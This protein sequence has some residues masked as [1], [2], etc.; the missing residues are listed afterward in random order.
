MKYLG[1]NKRWNMLRRI[2]TY[3]DA[4]PKIM[5]NFYCDTVL[6]MLLYCSETWILTDIIKRILEEFHHR[7]DRALNRKKF[8]KFWKHQYGDRQINWSRVRQSNQEVLQFVKMKSIG[9]YW[10]SRTQPFLGGQSSENERGV[11]YW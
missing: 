9:K 10:M 11:E 5:K 6:P 2:A 7:I 8:V 3:W 1:E 4:N